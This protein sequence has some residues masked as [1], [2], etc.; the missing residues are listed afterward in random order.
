M[1][2]LVICSLAFSA[3]IGVVAV[4]PTN[5]GDDEAKKKIE[6]IRKELDDLTKKEKELA[7]ERDEVIKKEKDLAKQ[8]ENLQKQIDAVQREAHRRAEELRI[9]KE[10]AKKAFEEA[11]KKKHYA[12]IELRGKL[13]NPK[14]TPQF[15]RLWFVL[16]N[17]N[18]WPL[19]IGDDKQELRKSLEKLADEPVIVTGTISTSRRNQPMIYPMFPDEISPFPRPIRD[20][21]INPGLPYGLSMLEL[22]LPVNVESI[23]L[24]E[25]K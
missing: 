12:R 10:M 20:P 5:A 25:E 4:A 24:F 15:S 16:T 6:Q 8:R 9:K 13:I 11:D 1:K 23:R 2:R 18:V 17:E 22:Q 21:R 14:G 3:L 7:K 19:Q